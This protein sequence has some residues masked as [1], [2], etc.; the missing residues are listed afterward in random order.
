MGPVDKTVEFDRTDQLKT[1]GSRTGIG[2]LVVFEASSG[3]SAQGRRSGIS[4]RRLC[5]DRLDRASPGRGG[6]GAVT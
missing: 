1:L 4:R 3:R 5:E 6:A 2:I